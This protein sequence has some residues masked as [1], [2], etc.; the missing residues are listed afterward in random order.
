MCLGLSPEF[1]CLR[2]VGP[3]IPQRMH[4]HQIVN[5]PAGLSKTSEAPLPVLGLTNHVAS[6]ISQKR[7]ASQARLL[8]E[9]TFDCLSD[10]VLA[11]GGSKQDMLVEEGPSELRARCF[12]VYGGREVATCFGSGE[13]VMYGLDYTVDEAALSGHGL[14][15]AVS[16]IEQR[17]EDYP[18]WPFGHAL[19]KIGQGGDEVPFEVDG[20]DSGH[21][22]A[23]YSVDSVEQ[24]RG[25]V[26]PVAVDRGASNAGFR[27]DTHCGERSGALSD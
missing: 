23:H 21:M 8:A 12:D 15:L 19:P 20:D 3:L 27:G 7:L 5:L 6:L 22:R 4:V 2:I 1:E 9:K 11:D 24:Q 18:E 13:D 16:V 14:T 26:G 25:R 10:E 17:G